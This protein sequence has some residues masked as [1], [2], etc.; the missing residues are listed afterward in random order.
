MPE[1]EVK[2]WLELLNGGGNIAAIAAV[3]LAMRIFQ[4][5][6]AIMD[7]VATRLARIERAIV[8]RDPDSNRI[9]NGPETEEGNA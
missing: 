7:K 4:R 9:I 5:F 1:A 8:A 2:G 3:Y 6:E